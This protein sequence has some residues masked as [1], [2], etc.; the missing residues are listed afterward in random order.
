MFVLLDDE[1][2]ERI[3]KYVWSGAIVRN[4]VKVQRQKTEWKRY[5]NDAGVFTKAVKYIVRTTIANAVLQLDSIFLIDHK[6]RNPLNNQKSNLRIATGSENQ[7]NKTK[8][9]YRN[10]QYSVYKGVTFSI[11]RKKWRAVIQFN[12]KRINIGSYNTEVEAALAWNKEAEK[13]HKEFAVLNEIK[14]ENTTK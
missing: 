11:Q 2:Y 10:S 5:F 4:Y 7:Y 9:L 6:D 12:K 8:Y 3:S 13:L 14:N 1:D